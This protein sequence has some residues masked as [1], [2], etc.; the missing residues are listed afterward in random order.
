MHKRTYIFVY[1]TCMLARFHEIVM[2]HSSVS[3]AVAFAAV[4]HTRSS[5][6][7]H[8]R[9]ATR[10]CMH[11]TCNMPLVITIKTFA[12]THTHT[13][14]RVHV[15]TFLPIL[16]YVFVALTYSPYHMRHFVIL[17]RLLWCTLI[18]CVLVCLYVCTHTSALSYR[19]PLLLLAYIRVLMNA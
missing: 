17:L 2:Q 3:F 7:L 12:L 10:T 14:I 8:T 15:C 19:L 5:T 13:H 16:F 11:A 1:G 9:L 18:T 6:Q 4:L